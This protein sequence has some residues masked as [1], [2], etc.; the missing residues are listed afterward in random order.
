[1]R[2]IRITRGPIAIG[3][4]FMDSGSGGGPSGPPKQPHDE[5]SPIP[6]KEPSWWERFLAW[7]ARI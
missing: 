2:P 1:M 3:P 7:L 6:P 5:P 4:Y